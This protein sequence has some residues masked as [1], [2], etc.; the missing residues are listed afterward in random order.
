MEDLLDDEY[1]ELKSESY[2]E[3]IL[4]FIN[5]YYE[6]KVEYD[7]AISRAIEKEGWLKLR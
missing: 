1:S 3:I 6:K 2:H 5:K 4:F 7:R